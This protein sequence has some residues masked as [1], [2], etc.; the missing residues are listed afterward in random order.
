MAVTDRPENKKPLKD[1][2]DLTVAEDR[3]AEIHTADEEEEL[4][5][6]LVRALQTA[7][8]TNDEAAIGSL[9]EDVRSADLADVLEL[10]DVGT[11][12]ALVDELRAVFDPDVLAEM[13]GRA[14]DDVISVLEPAE[15]AHALSHL[16]TDDAVDVLEEMDVDERDEV[17]VQVPA[18][19]RSIIEEGLAY[20]QD[21]AGRL[22]QRDLIA[23]P[24]Y[25]S[26]GQ[27]IDF[28]RQGSSHA[29]DFWEIFVVDPQHHPIGTMPLS[30]ILKA[31]RDTVLSDIMQVEQTLIPVNMDQ[32]EV[33][34]R[35][36][37]Y[38]LV[39]AAV[40]TEEGRLVGVITVDDVVDV[41]EEE[42]EED[43]LGLAG[44]REGDIN[45]SVREISK[46]RLGWLVL[47]LFTAILASIVIAMFGATIEQLVAL[48]ILMPIVASMGGNAATQSMAVAVRALASKELT[49]ANAT[50]VVLKELAVGLINGVLLALIMG[51]IS[52]LWFENS[53]LGIVIG[54][55]MIINMAVAGLSGT[56]VPLVLDKM[57]I[58]PAVSSSVF[59]TTITDVVGF[60]AFLG[61][62]AIFLL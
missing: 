16:E 34:Y 6:E 23:A 36:R 57:E 33:A 26:V 21:S 61:L 50:R 27:V 58:D 11:R 13:E 35:F 53:N 51:F 12:K 43:I 59:V 20:P 3:T 32:E 18:D 60:L 15:I 39:S 1:E 19:E 25:W 49:P 5:T 37:Q 52:A 10:L 46:T 4:Q 30:R 14:L 9:V 40:V 7:V 56:L 47:N 41:I 17:L 28:L 45:I 31:T 48:A 22:M 8:R 44:V 29:E 2:M 55:A 38:N 62:A 54:A 24:S 42:A